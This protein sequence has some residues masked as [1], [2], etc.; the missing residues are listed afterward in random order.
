MEFKH[1]EGKGK[2]LK[3]VALKVT[4][5]SI[6]I[7]E[8]KEYLVIETWGKYDDVYGHGLTIVDDDNET[9]SILEMGDHEVK[10]GN[11]IVTER[12]SAQP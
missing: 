10:G 1:I 9:H 8:C 7:T 5:K 4:D 6:D 3:V 2:P 11:W 12:E